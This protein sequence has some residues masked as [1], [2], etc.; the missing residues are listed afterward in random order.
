MLEVKFAPQGGEAHGTMKTAPVLR[1]HHCVL[2]S[3]K[4]IAQL[5]EELH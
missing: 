4:I 1:M 2:S 3:A 5:H